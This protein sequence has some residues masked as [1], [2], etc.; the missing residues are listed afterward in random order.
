MIGGEARAVVGFVI[1][2]VN[3]YGIPDVKSLV[4]TTVNFNFLSANNP[5]RAL[6]PSE[7]LSAWVPESSI[8]PEFQN[9][10]EIVTILVAARG[11]TV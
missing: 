9:N 3:V 10:P 2:K 8:A 4:A 11:T 5:F 1:W 7:N 6:E